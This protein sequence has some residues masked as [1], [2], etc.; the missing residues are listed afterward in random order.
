MQSLTSIR[1]ISLIVVI[2]GCCGLSETLLSQMPCQVTF[3]TASLSIPYVKGEPPLDIDPTSVTWKTTGTATIVKNCSRNVD[4]PDLNTKAR[5]FWTDS[6]LYLR[7]AC[8]YRSLNRFP[9][10][11]DGADRDKLW[12]R[13]V[14]E[15]F[16]GDDWKNIRHYREYEIAPTGERVDWRLTLTGEA[17]ADRGIQAGRHEPESMKQPRSGTRPPEFLWRPCRARKWFQARVGV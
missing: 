15:V 1:R 11:A 2:L 12:D 17:R 8:P 16:L 10:A 7:F 4:Y 13:D 3:P 5:G 9:L 14:V 6:A